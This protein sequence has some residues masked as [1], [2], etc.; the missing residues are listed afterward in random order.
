M[1]SSINKGLLFFLS[2]PFLVGIHALVAPSCAHGTLYIDMNGD[3][4]TYCDVTLEEFTTIGFTYHVTVGF[5]IIDPALLD[6]DG[7]LI[8]LTGGKGIYVLSACIGVPYI[9]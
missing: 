9:M 5:S 2:Q 4:I 1:L 7:A 8:Q 3:R 6:F